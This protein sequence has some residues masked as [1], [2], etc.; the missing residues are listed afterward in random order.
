VATLPVLT[1]GPTAFMKTN[2]IHSLDL[3]RGICG[4]GVAITHFY[5]Y[6]YQDLFSEY[7]SLLFVEWF[8]VLSGF[9][10]YPQLIKV[11]N[12]KRHLKTFYIRRWVR[13]LPLYALALFCASMVTA[14][15]FNADFFKY[16]VFAQ[17]LLPDFISDDFY[18]VAW[19]LSIEE[20]FYLFFPLF[21]I[22]LN[23]VK[24]INKV[25]ILF[26]GMTLVKV[27]LSDSV[28]LSFYRTGTLFRLDSILLGFIGAHFKGRIVQ[29]GKLVVAAVVALF[30]V[31]L[32]VQEAI[33]LGQ[34]SNTGK[35]LFVALLQLN[36]FFLLFGFI[37]A[38]GLIKNDYLQRFCGL[39]A[40]QTYSIYLFH[41]IFL[42]IIKA[43]FMSVEG[44]FVYYLA[45]LFF[46]SFVIYEFFEKPL[47]NL[48]PQYKAA[49]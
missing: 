49:I 43:N 25:L 28:D 46:V 39:L 15:L 21:L 2:K 40:N 1:N 8:F 23:K 32:Y 14:S 34:V 16:L 37:L 27:A 5:V 3:Y 22:L 9:V 36:S 42:Y 24:F 31:F 35:I 33:F 30:A 44:V 45:A 11:L 4:Y 48:R 19:S 29:H 38:D 7:F 6:L 20:Y 26:V 17:K 12:D 13:T 10:L 41:L 47:L 18:P